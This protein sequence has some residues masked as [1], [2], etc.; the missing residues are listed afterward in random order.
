MIKKLVSRS[1]IAL[2]GFQKKLENM[3]LTDFDG[4][5]VRDCVS[6]IGNANRMLKDHKCVPSDFKTMILE[7]LSH[8]SCSRFVSKVDQIRN[9]IELKEKNYEVDQILNILEED[10][11]DKIGSGKWTA[12]DNNK[13]E[14]STFSITLQDTMCLN[15]GKFGHMIKDCPEALDQQAIAKRKKLIFKQKEGTQTNG[16][17][18]NSNRGKENNFNSNN[19]SGKKDPKKQPP[20]TGEAHVKTFNNKKLFW[21]GKCGRWGNHKTADHKTKEE[22]EALKNKNKDSGN[23]DG[24]KANVVIGGA[25]A[26]NFG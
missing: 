10:Y 20:K 26:L 16:D 15:C 11:T 5:N 4:E 14:G 17:N 21:C 24:E 2:R 1:E 25:S 22:L 6:F 13:V 8:C 3:K 19:N 7:I 12:K 23:D 18:S 9:L